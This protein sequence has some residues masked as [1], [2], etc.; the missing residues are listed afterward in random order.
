MKSFIKTLA[1][2]LY[3]QKRLLQEYAYLRVNHG[4]V[5]KSTTINKSR[6]S[7][8]MQAHIIEK[9]LSL[10]DVR[11]GFGVPKV[12]R[13]ISDLKVHMD[14]FADNDLFAM[15]I[16]IIESYI[17][18]NRHNN[19]LDSKI[20]A[21]FEELKSMN[22]AVEQGCSGGVC[23]FSKQELQ[24]NNGFNYEKFVASRHSI[25][26]FT[27]D[28]VEE[29]L[30]RKALKIAETT[31]SACNRQPWHNYVF[32]NKNNIKQIVELQGGGRQFS[33]DIGALILIA[34]SADSFFGDEIGQHYVNGGLY[35]MNLLLAL[36]SL[37]LGTIPL[38][39][40]LPMQKIKAIRKLCNMQN[41]EMPILLIAVGIIPETLD[42]AVS[43]RF[44]YEQY[45]KF[46]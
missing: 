3:I 46:D 39:M 2:R 29:S 14:L 8:L 40:G 36:H 31:P 44:Q 34:S 10:K 38:N 17:C 37:G 20:V 32:T 15:I 22:A 6:A 35:S 41:N 24:P 1:T 11:P 42:V 9:G 28:L 23:R 7:I 21:L 27:G 33:D 26:N 19:M 18:F 12:I 43:H 4:N 30:I 13:L 45:T 5:N 25:R 16:P